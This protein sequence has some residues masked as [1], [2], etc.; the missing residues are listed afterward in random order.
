MHI[1]IL[2]GIESDM[3]ITSKLIDAQNHLFAMQSEQLE[4]PEIKTIRMGIRELF[5]HIYRR[6]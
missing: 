5:A 1:A 6:R 3:A 2:Q 4:I